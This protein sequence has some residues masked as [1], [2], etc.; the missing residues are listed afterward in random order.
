[1]KVTLI[2]LLSILLIWMAISF[3]TSRV[4]EPTYKLIKQADGFEIR[5]YDSYILA[6]VDVQGN[7]TEATN[8]GFRILAGYIFG[9]NQRKLSIKMTAPVV[10]SN[11]SEKIA[12]TAP[13]LETNSSLTEMRTIAFVMPQQYNL[14]SLPIPNNDNIKFEEVPE[15]YVAVL[16]YSW[17]TNEARV[18]KKKEQLLK[19]LKKQNIEVMAQPQNARYNPPWTVPFM[20]RNEILVDIQYNG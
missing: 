2:I 1:M 15:R 20:I 13:V 6:K 7:Y 17:Y 8:E 19:M 11:A 12:M 3:F 4:S 16:S 5:K 9:G 10:E 14:N 18:N